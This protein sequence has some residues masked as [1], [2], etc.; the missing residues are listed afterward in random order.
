MKHSPGGQNPTGGCIV[1]IAATR[2]DN[3][4]NFKFAAPGNAFGITAVVLCSKEP[5]GS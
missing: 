4:S 5:G 2:R 3:G 1:L